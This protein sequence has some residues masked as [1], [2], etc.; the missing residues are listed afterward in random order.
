MDVEDSE[1]EDEGSEDLSDD[2][3]QDIGIESLINP[4]SEVNG[5]LIQFYF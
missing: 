2:G 3:M 5:L 1:E 4:S